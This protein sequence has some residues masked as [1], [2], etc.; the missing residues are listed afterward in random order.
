MPLANGSSTSR[1]S[2][3]ARWRISTAKRSSDVA[4]SASAESS[5][6][7]RSRAITWVES[8]IGLEAELLARDALD[9][10]LQLGV[11]ADGAG[12]L[13]DAVL[14]ERPRNSCASA[15]ELEGPARQLPAE[16]DRLGVDAVR[17][18]DH[19][20]RSV[21]FRAPDDRGEGAVDPLEDERAG[22]LDLQ[23]EACV[24]DVRRR[25]AEMNPASLRAE[26]LGHRID[27]RG[28][29]V[30]GD[31]LDLGHAFRRG[32]GDALADR[33]DV[34]LRDLTDAR[35]A[36]EC[37]QL[38]VEPTPELVLVRPDP[39]HRR[40]GVARNHWFDSRLRA[41]RAG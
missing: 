38:D 26:L 31:A 34:V 13:P 17:A 40:S 33:A 5:A 37:R 6:A 1:T 10:G 35:P 14:L 8:G 16:G 27:E 36:L 39:R 24:D 3:R 21:L 32:H 41:G 23:R 29:V 11:G 4:A 18:A 2:V 28:R 30:V 19:H 9:L 15:V 25:E 12:Q 22:I 20:R 7:C